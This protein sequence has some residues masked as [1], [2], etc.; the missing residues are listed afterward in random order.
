M[1]RIAGSCDFEL[2]F[3]IRMLGK[4]DNHSKGT[5]PRANIQLFYTTNLDQAGWIGKVVC[6][7]PEM[8]LG[9]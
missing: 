1:I 8:K 3:V 9:E 4:I 5:V 2:S 6:E 7:F